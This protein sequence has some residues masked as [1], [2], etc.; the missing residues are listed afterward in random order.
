MEEVCERLFELT[1]PPVGLEPIELIVEPW[2]RTSELSVKN[3]TVE[4][5]GLSDDVQCHASQPGENLNASSSGL[6]RDIFGPDI[7]ELRGC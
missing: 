1:C 3:D 6:Q 2:V 7:A 5:T 4:R